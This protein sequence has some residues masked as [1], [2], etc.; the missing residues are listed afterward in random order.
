[1]VQVPVEF[2]TVVLEKVSEL[3]PV[4]R[5]S[6]V[7]QSA[8]ERFIRGLPAEMAHEIM[9]EAPP[10]GLI[11]SEFHIPAKSALAP[12]SLVTFPVMDKFSAEYHWLGVRCYP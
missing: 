7:T 12:F 11:I 2:E 5:P 3:P 6:I 1:M 9:R 4:F 8:P 10:S